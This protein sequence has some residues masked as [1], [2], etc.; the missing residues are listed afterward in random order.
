VGKFRELGTWPKGKA[1]LSISKFFKTIG[2]KTI[3]KRPGK[4]ARGV[5]VNRV[6]WL[7]L[8]GN[9]RKKKVQ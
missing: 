5:Q 3:G 7:L 6:S 2:D 4:K 8:S 1:T 9:G